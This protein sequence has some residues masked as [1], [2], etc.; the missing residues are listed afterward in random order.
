[1]GVTIDGGAGGDEHFGECLG[2]GDRIQESL[3][4]QHIHPGDFNGLLQHS[5]HPD[6]RRHVIDTISLN[7]R[8]IEVLPCEQ[9]TLFKMTLFLI[10]ARQVAL[11]SRAQ[12][13]NHR[14]RVAFGEVMLRKMGSNESC[15]AS[16]KNI[17]VMVG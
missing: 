16:D 3:C 4:A 9:V 7:N 10:E 8:F 15:A 12:V 1:M 14:D 13:I 11:T 2:S 5:K 6:H 17:Q